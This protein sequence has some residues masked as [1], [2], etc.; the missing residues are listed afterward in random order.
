MGNNRP[1]KVWSGSHD[2]FFLF[3]GPILI[4]GTDECRL[5]CTLTVVLAYA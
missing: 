5:V 2:Q 1:K 3:R 4:F